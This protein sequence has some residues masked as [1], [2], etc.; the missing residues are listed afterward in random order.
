MSE[1]LMDIRFRLR[2]GICNDKCRVR[3]AKSGC[4]CAEAADE[5]EWLRAEVQ[6]IARAA[7]GEK[8]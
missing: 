7:L 3:D 1:P 2:M 8:G 4:A 5:I 6:R